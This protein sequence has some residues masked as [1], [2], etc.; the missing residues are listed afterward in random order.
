M[1]IFQAPNKPIIVALVAAVIGFFV[2]GVVQG[3]VATIFYMAIIIWAYE[4]IVH[5]VNW[6]RRGLG[7]VVMVAIL[8]S[9]GSQLGH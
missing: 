6:F 2:S 8:I 7:S 1:V 5:G 4:E 9:L 3:Y